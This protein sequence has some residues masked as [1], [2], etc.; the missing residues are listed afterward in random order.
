MTMRDPKQCN[1]LIKPGEKRPDGLHLLGILVA[2]V[3]M[4]IVWEVLL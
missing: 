4:L 2:V 3:V 1:M